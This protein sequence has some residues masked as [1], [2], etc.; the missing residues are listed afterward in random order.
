MLRVKM[1]L[2]MFIFTAVIILPAPGFASTYLIGSGIYDI[3][4]PAGEIV[5]QGFAVSSQTTAGIHT[6]LR[7]RAFVI[8]DGAKRVVFVS[9]DL[10]M[11]FQMVKV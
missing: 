9:A 8:G 1:I 4:G 6:R 3:T 5:M 11:L 2:I 7:S 10:G